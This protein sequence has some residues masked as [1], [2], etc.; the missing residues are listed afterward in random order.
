[1]S[2]PA[3]DGWIQARRAE[4]PGLIT[5][6]PTLAEAKALLAAARRE[7]LLAF[8]EVEGRPRRHR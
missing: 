1:M 2:E 6:T 5:A 7:Y 4:L 8:G 3:E